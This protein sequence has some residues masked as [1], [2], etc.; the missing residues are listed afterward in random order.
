MVFNRNKHSSA[1]I[2]D[3]MLLQ[4]IISSPFSLVFKIYV[5]LVTFLKTIWG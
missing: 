4:F 2:Q 5:T 1:G 3:E